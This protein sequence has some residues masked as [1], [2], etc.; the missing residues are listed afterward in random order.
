MKYPEQFNPHDSKYEKIED[1]PKEERQNFKKSGDGFVGRDAIEINKASGEASR[2]Q[3][4]V[5]YWGAKDYT[6]AESKIKEQ[7]EGLFKAYLRDGEISK[8]FKLVNEI[9]LPK[10]FIYSS[11]NNELA[12]QA[13]TKKLYW[14]YGNLNEATLVKK[15]FSVSEEVILSPEVQEAALDRI[16]K[17]L[18]WSND[19][20]PQTKKYPEM[21]DAVKKEFLVTDEKV[22]ELIEDSIVWK[23]GTIYASSIPAMISVYGLS[24]E[25]L[26]SKKI[27]Q[28]AMGAIMEK[29]SKG[30]ITSAFKIKQ[31]LGLSAEEVKSAEM[32]VGKEGII[33]SMETESDLAKKIEELERSKGSDTL[34][35][36]EEMEKK[37]SEMA[38]LFNENEYQKIDPEGLLKKYYNEELKKYISEGG[39]LSD[40]EFLKEV[41]PATGDYAYLGRTVGLKEMSRETADKIYNFYQNMALNVIYFENNRKVA[42][43]ALSK[44]FATFSNSRF[45]KENGGRYG[46]SH[47]CACNLAGELGYIANKLGFP[48]LADRFGRSTRCPEGPQYSRGGTENLYTPG[49]GSP[50]SIGEEYSDDKIKENVLAEIKR[51]IELLK[52]KAEKEKGQQ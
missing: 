50:L 32:S 18:Y 23:L 4:Q 46:E 8:A 5:E 36:R 21:I 28:A 12:I 1:L 37:L 45:F 13:M 24:K 2:M 38:S 6:E 17:A 47:M 49:Y 29:L 15:D 11:E 9:H 3:A 35:R 27:K 25:L 43:E 52:Q 33:S 19:N 42:K 48:D 16:E 20:D 40:P 41:G 31:S 7:M 22:N 34:K 44:A 39:S 30:D 10:E 14:N 51:E 26:S